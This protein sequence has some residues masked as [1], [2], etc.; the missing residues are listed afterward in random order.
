MPSLCSSS[1]KIIGQEYLIFYYGLY[2]AFSTG[3]H[4]KNAGM[5]RDLL[6]SSKK[7]FI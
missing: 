4:K 7:M 2:F 1:Q 5:V 3:K 6:L